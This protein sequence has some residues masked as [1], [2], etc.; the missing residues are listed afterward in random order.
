ME[1]VPGT[2][3]ENLRNALGLAEGAPPPWQGRLHAFGVPF[4]YRTDIARQRSPERFME[5]R[6]ACSLALRSKPPLA[7][8]AC[9]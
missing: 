7:V 5:V 4:D 1:F 9:E 8:L 6:S 3:S 2:L